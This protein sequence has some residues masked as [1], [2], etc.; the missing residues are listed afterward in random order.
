MAAPPRSPAL[1]GPACK[2]RTIASA[3]AR[4]TSC[5]N[6][7]LRNHGVESEQSHRKARPPGPTSINSHNVVPPKQLMIGF[8]PPVWAVRNDSPFCPVGRDRRSGGRAHHRPCLPKPLQLTNEA[9]VRVHRRNG[10]VAA[11]MAD[12]TRSD[13]R[14]IILLQIQEAPAVASC[15]CIPISDV[16]SR[17]HLRP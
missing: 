8:H 1:P 12:E 5:G 4:S 10:V 17:R 3:A 16:C 11:K 13:H 15:L 14:T 9:R 6:V 2:A 7:V